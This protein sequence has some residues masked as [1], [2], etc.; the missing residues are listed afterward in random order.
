MSF[1]QFRIIQIEKGPQ[2]LNDNPL[3]ELPRE[4]AHVEFILMRTDVTCMP[5]SHIHVLRPSSH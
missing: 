5:D 3:F 2:L 4:N 1:V